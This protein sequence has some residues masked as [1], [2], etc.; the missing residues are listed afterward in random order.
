MAIREIKINRAR[1]EWVRERDTRKKEVAMMLCVSVCPRVCECGYVYSACGGQKSMSDV[2]LD[3][4][5]L[6]LFLVFNLCV[7]V[8]P[9]SPGNIRYPG[10]GV[11]GHCEPLAVGAWRRTEVP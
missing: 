5:H 11:T 9:R 6:I 4:Y 7:F 2:F 3:C 1:R 10:V 8:C